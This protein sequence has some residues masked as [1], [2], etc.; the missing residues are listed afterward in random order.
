MTKSLCCEPAWLLVASSFS[1]IA[2][3]HASRSAWRPAG[4]SAPGAAASACPAR[5]RRPCGGRRAAVAP[6]IEEGGGG[7]DVDARRRAGCARSQRS[8]SMAIASW[9]ARY[10]GPAFSASSVS[11]PMHAVRLESEIGLQ[12]A[13]PP[14]R[15]RANRCRGV[16][17]P[18][19]LV[20]RCCRRQIAAGLQRR[21]DRGMRGSR[22][23]G[24]I[25]LPRGTG[26]NCACRRELQEVEVR[27]AQRPIFVGLRGE[28]VEPSLTLP[29]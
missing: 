15:A 8:R 25:G 27:L 28:R 26:W 6:I 19:A 5:R 12:S 21:D 10:A 22:L 18:A 3:G 7:V 2:F 20:G 29:F 1:A 16:R 14:R 24:L 17:R 11:L 23:P 9:R 13:S 4:R